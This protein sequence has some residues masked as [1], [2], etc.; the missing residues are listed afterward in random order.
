MTLTDA[1]V[2]GYFVWSTILIITMAAT[3]HRVKRELARMR[4]H[5]DAYDV[6]LTIW[7]RDG[8]K[9][10]ETREPVARIE[11]EDGT[12]PLPVVAE[13]AGGWYERTV[14]LEPPPGTRVPGVDERL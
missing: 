8:V 6:K 9:I 13:D 4:R 3:R 12:L 14:D 11:R 5:L 7:Y 2:L 1:L 10:K